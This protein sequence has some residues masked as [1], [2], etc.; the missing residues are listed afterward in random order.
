MKSNLNMIT[1]YILVFLIFS[2]TIVFSQTPKKVLFIGNSITYFNDMPILFE[3]IAN[4]RGKNIDVEVYAPGG[5]G[6]ANHVV[7]NNVYNLFRNYIWDIVILQ[8]GTGESA[9]VSWP[10]SIT[11]QRGLQMMDSIKKYSPCAKIFLYEIPYGVTMAN[12]YSTYFQVQTQIKDTLTKMADI[13]Q[14]PFVAAGECTR[15]HYT[16]QQDLLLHSSYGDVHPN[17]NGSYLVACAMYCTIFQEPVSNVNF[18]G[19]VTDSIANYF[20]DIADNVILANKPN[21]RIN[22]Y[23]LHAEFSSVNLGGG[24]INFTNLSTNFTSV[25]WDF[26]DGATATSINPLHQY[27]TAGNKIITITATRNGCSETFSK[28]INIAPLAMADLNASS[29]FKMY[30]NPATTILTVKQ[31]LVKCIT[32]KIVNITGQVLQTGIIN[33]A[34]KQIPVSLLADGIYYLHLLDN[35]KSIGQQKFIK[36]AQ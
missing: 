31:D 4:E 25:L 30:P 14:I 32:Y 6:F 2:S 22:T 29:S 23:D 1:K 7:D 12:A 11:A 9:G 33:N 10:A 18:N 36:K 15:Q 8:P 24:L 13:M 16:A 21:W 5:T 17:L 34:E 28:T 35:N 19:G 27:T 3:S 20:Q 26:G